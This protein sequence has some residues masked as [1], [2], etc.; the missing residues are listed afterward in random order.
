MLYQN[1][2]VIVEYHT[3]EYCAKFELTHRLDGPGDGPLA[4]NPEA[5]RCSAR[6]SEALLERGR[7]IMGRAWLASSMLHSSRTAQ[8]TSLT[9][10]VT[11]SV[12]PT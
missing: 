3:Q 2:L 1:L 9:S 11:S 10:R 7:P 4:R 12:P 6:A 8:K 5:A